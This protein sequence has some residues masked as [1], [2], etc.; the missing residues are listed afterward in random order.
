MS[1]L[2]LPSISW[3][4]YVLW[5][6]Q[7]CAGGVND[8]DG[9]DG[10]AGGNGGAQEDEDDSYFHTDHEGSITYSVT[11]KKDALSDMIIESLIKLYNNVFY[12]V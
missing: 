11:H 9:H 12:V 7:P 5:S 1:I 2:A 4:I 10:A 6:W 3:L 8:G